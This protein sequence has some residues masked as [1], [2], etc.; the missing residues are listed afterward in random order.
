MIGPL[1]ACGSYDCPDSLE[2]LLKQFLGEYTDILPVPVLGV[3]V[4]GAIALASYIET[5]SVLIP[6]GYVMLTGGAVLTF[7]APPAYQVAT[8]LV[9]FV[10]AGAIT[11]M[12]YVYST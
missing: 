3:F 10:S 7:L 6:T 9:L 8:L 5:D 4:F 11:F 2:G 1:A 12:W